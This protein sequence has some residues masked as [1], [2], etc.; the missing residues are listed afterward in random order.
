MAAK[1]ELNN[2]LNTMRHP[3]TAFLLALPVCLLEKATEARGARARL[4]RS[5]LG[6]KEELK[7]NKQAPK[8]KHEHDAARGKREKKKGKSI[9]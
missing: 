2:E 9:K 3:S 7:N 5:H 8:G 6:Q 1:C 4:R